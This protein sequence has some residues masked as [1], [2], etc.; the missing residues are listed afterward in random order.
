[1]ETKLCF[2]IP[3]LEADTH[4]HHFH[5][6]ELLEELVKEIKIFLVVD[7]PVINRYLLS[8]V[9]HVYCTKFD[10]FPLRKIE[11]LFIFCC[12][13]IKGYKT[14]YIHYSLW[15]G[16]LTA[17]VTKLLGGKT[18]IWHCHVYKRE[19]LKEVSSVDELRRWF[20][21]LLQT[22][23]FK[24][25]DYIVTGTSSVVSDYVEEFHAAEEKFIIFPNWV[26]LERFNTADL[27]AK[28]R[29]CEN[30][31]VTFV[32][33]LTKEKG[34]PYLPLIIKKVTNAMG[35]VSF[36]IVGDGTYRGAIEEEIKKDGVQNRVRFVGYIPNKEIPRFLY[37]TDLLIVPSDNEG[38]P[39]VL[40]E[41]M[42]MGVPFV[43]TNVGGVMDIVVPP[44]TEYIVEKG[45][46]EGFSKKVI[47]LLNDDSMRERLSKVGLE[48]VKEYTLEKAVERFKNILS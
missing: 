46:I 30:K 19:R 7:K 43:A 17:F 14:F 25:V 9:E 18:Y 15:N 28:S 31:V 20:N 36:D 33:S 23:T 40:L 34:A 22:F 47:D 38:F 41:A 10:L 37:S 42:A 39:R 16:L 24:A 4:S 32:H 29:K 44:Q 8:N 12:A 5:I 11:Q 6:Y 26:N 48:R 13:R 1:M 35:D 21:G 45:D 3:E 27:T 2:S